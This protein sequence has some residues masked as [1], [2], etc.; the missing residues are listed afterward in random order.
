MSLGMTCSQAVNGSQGCVS[1]GGDRAQALRP[2]LGG[3]HHL[4]AL[5]LDWGCRAPV[6]AD[7]RATR[8]CDQHDRGHDREPAEE[9]QVLLWPHF[10]LQINRAPEM[11]PRTDELP[12]EI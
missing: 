9:A 3:E 5:L 8:R 7:V 4:A 6:P 1:A 2:L 12:L 11:T 10:H